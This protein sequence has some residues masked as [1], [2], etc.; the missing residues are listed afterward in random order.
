MAVLLIGLQGC[1]AEPSLSAPALF[2]QL[3]RESDEKL[4]RGILSRIEDHQ[5]SRSKL[6]QLPPEHKTVR[7]IAWFRAIFGNG[8]LQYWFECDSED[9]GVATVEDLRAVGLERSADALAKAYSLFERPED[10]SDFEKR[11]SA[12]RA[13]G[14]TIAECETVLWSE[15]GDLE[16]SGG[17]FVRRNRSAFDDLKTK[18]PYDPVSKSYG[19]DA[20]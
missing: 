20:K 13:H 17:K 18:L 3:F 7:R 5:W 6:R 12:I 9:Y 4:L 11:M 2:D 14:D 19:A 8:G 10:W 15:F 16:A 1:S